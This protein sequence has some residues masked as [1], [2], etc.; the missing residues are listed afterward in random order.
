MCLYFCS[1]LNI[2]DRFERSRRLV[3]H[4]LKRTPREYETFLDCL[5]ATYQR[6]LVINY[7]TN[8][9]KGIERQLRCVP[10]LKHYKSD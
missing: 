2:N 5:T 6:A 9:N 8:P 3:D 4:M 10:L 7:L 1:Q